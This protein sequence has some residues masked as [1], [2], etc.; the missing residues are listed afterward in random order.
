MKM[1]PIWQGKE[2]KCVEDLLHLESR[3]VW[4]SLLFDLMSDAE[5]VCPG[6]KG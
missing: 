6:A 5:K 1:G 2:G 3:F 4:R